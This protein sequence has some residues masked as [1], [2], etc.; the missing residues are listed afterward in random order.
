MVRSIGVAALV[1]LAGRATTRTSTHVGAMLVAPAGDRAF[2]TVER[3]STTTELVHDSDDQPIRHSAVTDTWVVEVDLVAGDQAL[4]AHE[5]GWL[6]VLGWAPADDVLWLLR[7]D[8]ADPTA[9]RVFGLRRDDR[10]IPPPAGFEPGGLP[11]VSGVVAQRPSLW[12]LASGAVVP[13]TDGWPIAEHVPHASADRAL[14]VGCAVHDTTVVHAVL[15]LAQAFRAGV[16]AAVTTELP[17]PA[18]S[19]PA[20]ACAASP[21][22]RQLAVLREHDAVLID[23]PTRSPVRTVPL[24]QRPTIDR[25]AYAGPGVLVV[26]ADR[27]AMLVDT[28]TGAARLLAPGCCDG[29]RPVDD[30]SAAVASARDRRSGLL[31]AGDGTT[32]SLPTAAALRFAEQTGLPPRPVLAPADRIAALPGGA[33][34]L[35]GITAGRTIVHVEDPTSA[36]FRIALAVHRR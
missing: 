5:D 11:Y 12:N 4:R 29:V 27:T 15:D 26:I 22:G 6:G 32:T 7:D 33:L 1:A 34:L 30:T 14:L 20:R 25:A 16:A 13:F 21:D 36:R 10:S 19:G 3:W 2:V 24:P 23:V 35:A 31:V 28:A 9:T 18:A 8:L 17:W